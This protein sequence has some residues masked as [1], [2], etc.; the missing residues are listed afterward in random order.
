MSKLIKTKGIVLLQRKYSES[1]IIASVYTEENGRETFYIPGA[2]KPKSKIKSNLFSPLS[3]LAIEQYRNEKGGLQKLKEANLLYPLHNIRMDIVKSSIALFV[4]ELLG[5]VLREEH[6]D[7]QLFAYIEH[8]IHLLDQLE[9]GTAN[10]HIM[11]MLELSR[12]LG[13]F[14]QENYSSS[15]SLFDMQNGCFVQKQAPA[16]L[17]AHT[18]QLIGLLQRHSMRN[19]GELQINHMQRASLL[20]SMLDY[21][22]WHIH[23]MGDMHSV[24]VL[25]SVFS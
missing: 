23:G 16:S 1:S 8:S 4:A 22:R 14:P 19:I 11:F 9:E 10:F 20:S 12:F 18:S 25:A 24:E 5:Q 7:K 13:F 21:Y 17:P 2:R 15:C 6:G 3:V